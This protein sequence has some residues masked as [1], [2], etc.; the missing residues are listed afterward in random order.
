VSLEID[1]IEVSSTSAYTWNTVTTMDGSHEIK[2][3]AVDTVKNSASTSI[4]VIVDNTPP[5]IQLSPPNGTEFYSDQNLTI[6]YNI[7]DATSGIA[8]SSATLDDTV[9]SKGDIIDLRNISIGS[10]VI[11]VTATDNAGNSAELSTTFIVKPLQAILDIEPRTLNINS[12]GRWIQ[13]EIQ[14][15]GYYAYQIEV[16][17]IRLNEVISVELKTSEIEEEDRN[18]DDSDSKLKVKFNRTEVQSIVTSGNV[19]LY[20]SG[21]VN[22]ATFMGNNTIRVIENPEKYSDH[23]EK[24]PEKNIG[25]DR[26]KGNEK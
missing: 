15:P 7:T 25:N 2:L 11:K 26:G 1:G 13:V 6:D 12:S 5:I 19:N 20:I 22:G 10:H 23:S 17:S 21:K 3:S 8:A 16:Y 18:K 24:D 14:I 4:N 9:V